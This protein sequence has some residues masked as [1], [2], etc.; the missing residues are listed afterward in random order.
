[1]LLNKEGPTGATGATGLAGATGA[2]GPAG[3]AG[4]GATGA[5]GATGPAGASGVKITELSTCGVGG[6]DLCKVG[7]VGPGGGHIFFVDYYDQYTGFNYLEAA[8]Q[9]WGNLIAINQGGLTGETTGSATVDPQMK[10]CSSTSALL[11][12]DAWANSAVGVGTS[13]T[14]TADTTCAGGA[15]QAAAD[16]AGGSQTD[17]FL[18]SIGEAML[19]YTNSRQAGVGGFATVYYWSS[20]EVDAS[21]AWIQYFV[22]GGQAYISK[23]ATYYVRP[24]R[25]F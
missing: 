20:S 2:V 21:N 11:G 13:N 9:G 17:W 4:A 15:I 1:M 23:N 16:Y 5:T 10:W 19:M 7:A 14:S 18:P 3:S 8:P 12:L 25:A 22:S 6:T 24:V